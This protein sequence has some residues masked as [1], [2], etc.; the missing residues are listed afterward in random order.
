MDDPTG[1]ARLADS[2]LFN[3]AY[4]DTLHGP[5]EEAGK[6]L[7]DATK[8]FR[9]FLA[10]IQLLAAAHDRLAA[11]CER[12]RRRVPEDRQI[13]AAPSIAA[14]LPLSLR[15]MEDDN[16]LTELFLN[17]LTRAIDRERFGEAHPAFV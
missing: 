16:V 8:T 2:K 14:P 12:V 5:M 17:L 15:Y 11:F 9:L 3:K 1:L 6:F 13:E 7:V 4:D 10:P